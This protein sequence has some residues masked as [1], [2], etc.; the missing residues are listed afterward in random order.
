MLENFPKKLLSNIVPFRMH[1]TGWLLVAFCVAIGVR[2]GGWKLGVPMGA[3]LVASLLLHEAGHMLMAIWLGVPVREFGIKLMGAYNRRAFATRRRDEI[4]ISAAGPLMNL[5]LVIPL[6]FIHKIGAQ[7][8]VDNLALCVINLLPIPSSDGMR[9][10]KNI[11]NSPSR[12]PSSTAA[13]IP[14][15]ATIPTGTM[16]PTFRPARSL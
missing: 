12:H 14:A 5:A 4:L 3:L 13:G 10:L 7:L 15:L 11:W 8:A 9:I 2:L 16:T 6:L 1:A